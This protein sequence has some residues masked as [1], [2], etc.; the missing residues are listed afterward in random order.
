MKWILGIAIAL[1]S[2]DTPPPCPSSPDAGT[3]ALQSAQVITPVGGEG[4]PSLGSLCYQQ[5]A[6][7]GNICRLNFS[8][9]CNWCVWGCYD[10][11]DRNLS[12]C[13]GMN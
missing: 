12:I 1:A 7:C 11:C 3:Q 9:W 4:G 6:T 2:C 8:G 5:W 10:S 13:L